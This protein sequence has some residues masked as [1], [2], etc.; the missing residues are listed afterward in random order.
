[1]KPA[2][3]NIVLPLVCLAALLLV[4]VFAIDSYTRHLFIIAFLYAIIASNWNL[5][6]G[7]CGVFNFG[8]LTFFG[9]GVYTAAILAKTLGVNPWIAILASGATAAAA[10]FLIAAP[11]ARLK[12]IYVVLVTFAFGQLVMQLV[13]S[14]AQITGGA[15]G[16]VRI[17]YLRLGDYSFLKDYK[18]GYYYAA[19]FLL[20]VSTLFLLAVVRSPFGKS[21]K[22]VRDAEEYAAARGISISRQRV[23]VLVLSAIFTGIAG[24][25]YAIYLRVAS[26]DVFGFGT[27]SLALSMVLIGGTGTVYGPIAAALALTFA[28]EALAGIRGLEEARFI[29]IA[30][31]MILVLRIA[32]GGLLGIIEKLDFRDRKPAAPAVARNGP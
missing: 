6:L 5:S 11:V 3:R 22:A 14:Q 9:V 25:F 4:P 31:A 17:P 27:L 24:G 12:G 7:H 13:L 8:H 16:M 19:L 23:T 20:V 26:P 2:A 21:L 29:L 28:T 30:L 32:P 18:L 15:E 1:M 10:A